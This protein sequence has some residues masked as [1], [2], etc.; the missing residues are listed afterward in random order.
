MDN[1]GQKVF[2]VFNPTA[3]KE[4]K[5]A[6]LRSALALHFPSPQWTVEIH[7]TTG[8]EDVTAICRAA[9][10]LLEA[11]RSPDQVAVGLTA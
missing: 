5:A 1:S 8:K 9:V 6:E 7:E 11:T 3:G 2:V 10:D 4:D